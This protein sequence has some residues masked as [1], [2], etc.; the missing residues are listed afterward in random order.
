MD[1]NLSK[2]LK[3]LGAPD[4]LDFFG[5]FNYNKDTDKTFRLVLRIPLRGLFFL[6]KFLMIS[7]S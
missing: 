4:F 7:N 2:K 6:L 1:N 5:V 3:A